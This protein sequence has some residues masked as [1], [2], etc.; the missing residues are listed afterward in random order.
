MTK[1]E[2]T[3]TEKEIREETICR[4]CGRIKDKGLI[5]CWYCFKYRKDIV[6]W[7]YF[8]GTFANWLNSFGR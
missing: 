7:K 8:E 6:P 1:I 4:G 5:V 2:I 3:I